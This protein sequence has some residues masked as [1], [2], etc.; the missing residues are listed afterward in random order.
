MYK[1][2]FK[3]WF[4]HLDFI[5]LDELCLVVS[6]VLAD[7]ISAY[8][9][10]AFSPP[11]APKLLLMM[12]FVNLAVS[13]AFDSLDGV[14]SRGYLVEFR[15]T[16]RHTLVVVVTVSVTL[17]ARVEHYCYPQS[18]G[19]FSMAFYTF[20]TYFTRV[21]WK[22]VVPHMSRHNGPQK[23]L[24]VVVEERHA[25]EIIRQM[26]RYS[27]GRY[28]LAGLILIDRDAAGTLLQGVPVVANLSEASDFICRSWVDDIL[29][30]R[31]SHD[32]RT[33]ELLEACREMA[34]TVHFYISLQGVQESKQAIEYIA[35]YEVLTANI[36]MMSGLDAMEKRAL[37]IVAGLVG[38]LLTGLILLV[39]GPIIYLQSPGPLIFKQ[40]RVGQNGR[41]F[42][43]YKIRSMYMDA[44]ERKQE[45]AALNS[46]GDGVMFKIDFDPR[47]I[48]NRVLPD[49]RQVRGI[50]D[51]IRRTSLDEF[52]QFWN[53]LRSDMSIVG[54]RPP[55]LDEWNQYH[56]RHRARMAIKPGLTGLWQ[57]N[58]HK[59]E[60]SL[61][62]VVRLDTEYI[63]NWSMG[64]D[65][66]II[67]KTVQKMFTG[68]LPKKK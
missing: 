29:F 28:H 15:A 61:D 34:L 43:I 37:D 57:I 1:K 67:L 50:G 18:I 25:P 20:S 36:N 6:L 60:L 11:D 40:T 33:Q 30:F 59:D 22:K 12:V 41:V 23:E 39:V 44:E 17:L 49:G 46:H 4:R 9:A 32:D 55:T 64:M 38:T 10:S 7:R 24:L 47:V 65:F 42:T 21:L 63:A 26:R 68:L 31:T 8:S 45:Y 13:T 62:D 58:E 14:M 51:F 53:L 2:A 52:P 3:T 16:L 54:T 19:L 66:R 35:G 5:L 56:L 48:G 27:Y